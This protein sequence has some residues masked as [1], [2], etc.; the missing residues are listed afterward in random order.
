MKL[1]RAALLTGGKLTGDFDTLIS[2][3]GISVGQLATLNPTFEASYSCFVSMRQGNADKKYDIVPICAGPF[4]WR[5]QEK[6]PSSPSFRQTG[7]L[8][9]SPTAVTI[10][11]R[12]CGIKR[13]S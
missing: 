8:I 12:L 6:V 3:R 1:F 2:S 7:V 5:H 10:C 11:G 4:M 9:N 13:L